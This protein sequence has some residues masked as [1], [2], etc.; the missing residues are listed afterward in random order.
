M[1]WSNDWII[2]FK[3]PLRYGHLPSSN[4]IT[5]EMFSQ[6]PSS[7]CPYQDIW[8]IFPDGFILE[9][10]HE[11]DELKD[12]FYEKLYQHFNSLDRHFDKNS[13]ILS[14]YCLERIVDV[15]LYEDDFKAVKIL[16][17]SSLPNLIDSDNNPELKHIKEQLENRLKNKLEIRN[18]Q[19]LPI[20]LQILP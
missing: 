19:P 5:S 1:E 10:S 17:C 20:N 15:T 2:E 4:I 18:S 13:T 11:L 8:Y 12:N 7:N 9:Q 16:A 3:F 6:L 14:D